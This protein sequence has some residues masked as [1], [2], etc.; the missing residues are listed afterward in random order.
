MPVDGRV[1]GEW[2]Y[3]IAAYAVT[4]VVLL[5]YALHLYRTWTAASRDADLGD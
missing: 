4:W 2:P 3:V 1:S 5:G